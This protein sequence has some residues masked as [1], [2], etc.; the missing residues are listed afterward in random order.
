MQV[1]VSVAPDAVEYVPAEHNKQFVSIIR[2]VAVEY[3]PELH[4]EQEETA[5]NRMPVEYVPGGHPV[6]EEEPETE[7]VPVVR[8]SIHT[9]ELVAP[10]TMLY[11]PTGQ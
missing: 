8:Q 2:P 4:R 5:V 10:R 3:F 6:Q 7:Y 9:S 11:F 1:K